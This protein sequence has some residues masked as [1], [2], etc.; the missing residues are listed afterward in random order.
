M[1]LSYI[2]EPCNGKEGY[3]VVHNISGLVSSFLEPNN[4]SPAFR[5]SFRLA[6]LLL[7]SN[8]IEDAYSLVCALYKHLEIIPSLD[9]GQVSRASYSTAL[10]Y[11]WYT[12]PAYPRPEK[13]HFNSSQ[14][15][16]VEA[17]RARFE[18]RQWRE[19]RECTR[20]GWMLEHCKLAEPDD[21]H[22]L[23]SN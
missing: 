4:L 5:R 12:H 13:S 17:A 7:L 22:P 16:P 19:Y 2:D 14:S 6:E 11:F 1:A 20:T 23:S 3:F 8:H 21:P 9:K 15:E 10:E 18:A